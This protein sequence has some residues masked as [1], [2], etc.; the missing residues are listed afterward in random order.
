MHI[1]KIDLN[2]M[3]VFDALM[4]ERSVTGAGRSL[5]MST[6]AVSHALARLRELVG[7]VL[8]LPNGRGVEPTSRAVEMA[9]RI[10]QGVSLLRAAL[11]PEPPVCDPKSLER[12]FFID[13]AVGHQIVLVPRLVAEL[14]A[15]GPGLRARIASDRASA[16]LDELRFGD[17]ELALDYEQP[18]AENL[19]A[20]K[21]FEDTYAIVA[22]RAHPDL[23]HGRFTANAFGSLGHVAL[24]WTRT[25]GNSPLVTRL[26]AQGI[27]RN[28]HVFVASLCSVPDLLERSDLVMVVSRHVAQRLARGRALRVLDMPFKLDP[29]PI[30]QIWHERHA[31]DPGHRWLRATMCRI[32]RNLTEATDDGVARRQRQLSKD[33]P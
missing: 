5:G 4:R 16:V 28:V 10:Q 2:L 27:Q 26:S 9:V 25:Q 22:R 31:H 19:V 33:Q 20:E 7:D 8:F 15:A 3:P 21:L 13:I 23:R 29:V 14:A 24:S 6:S 30:F 1:R 17:T 18:T 12:T 11:D 32:C